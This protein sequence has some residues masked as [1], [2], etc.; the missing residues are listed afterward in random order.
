MLTYKLMEYKLQPRIEKITGCLKKTTHPFATFDYT[1][2]NESVLVELKCRNCKKNKYDTTMIGMNKIKK[3]KNDN[4]AYFFFHFDDGLFYWKYK[5]DHNF[6]IIWGGR[7]DRGRSEMS[8]Y[9]HIPV[10]ELIEAPDADTSVQILCPA[11]C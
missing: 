8:D 7:N 6:Q 9:L 11:R 4:E 10:K 3:I 1:S 5:S 2:P